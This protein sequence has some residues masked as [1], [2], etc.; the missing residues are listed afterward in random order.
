M[1]RRI[2]FGFFSQIFKGSDWVLGDPWFTMVSA[3]RQT[4]LP[5]G[6]VVMAAVA[7]GLYS[8]SARGPSAAAAL[9]EAQMTSQLYQ[10]GDQEFL[11]MNSGARAPGQ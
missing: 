8:R 6:A 2:Y 10:I 9:S 4:W 7:V 3:A 11:A 1:R 5:L